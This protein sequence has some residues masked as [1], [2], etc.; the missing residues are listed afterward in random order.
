MKIEII[1]CS[2]TRLHQV[3]IDG[4]DLGDFDELDVGTYSYFPKKQDQ[5]TGDHYIEIGKALN[6]LNKA[7]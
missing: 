5:L 1:K 7:N 6:E 2:I 4:V 3:V